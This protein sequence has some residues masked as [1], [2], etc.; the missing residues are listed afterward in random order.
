MAKQKYYVVWAG[1]EPGI[2]ETWSEC[3]RQVKG[4]KGA[5]YKSFPT[6]TEAEQAFS[7]KPGQGIKKT[8]KKPLQRVQQDSGNDVIWDSISV[9]V[10]SHGNPGRVE[11]KGVDTKTGEVLFEKEPIKLGTNNMGEFLAIVHGLAYLKQKQL[12]KPVYSDSKTAISW[13]RKKKA[14]ST[15]PRDEKTEEIWSLIDRAEKWLKENPNHH[16]VL[17]WDTER[18]GEIKADYGRKS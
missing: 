8:A 4:F 13:V 18:N 1:K 12:S 6:K 15:L 17:K 10:G 11:Y 2:Y 5:R 16:Q 3:E 14:N 7:G 9:D